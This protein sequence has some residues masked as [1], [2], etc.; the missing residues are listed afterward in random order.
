MD[1]TLLKPKKCSKRPTSRARNHYIDLK[2]EKHATFHGF[3][4]KSP[5][6][7]DKIGKVVN[8]TLLW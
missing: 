1:K 8:L 7:N 3:F 6:G 5:D 2:E 4:M